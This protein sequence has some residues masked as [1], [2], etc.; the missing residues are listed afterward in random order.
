MTPLD[1]IEELIRDVE[2]LTFSMTRALAAGDLEAVGGL[3]AERGEALGS[4]DAARAALAPEQ[5]Q[6]L[7]EAL[8]SAGRARL[9]LTARRE[10]LRERIRD[11]RSGRK[12]NESFKTHEVATGGRLNVSF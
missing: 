3:L 2:A 9:Q 7:R 12:A 8:E 11:A 1:A 10:N 6:V 4:L 5:L